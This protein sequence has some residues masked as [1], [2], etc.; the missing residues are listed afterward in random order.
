MQKKQTLGQPPYSLEFYAEDD[1]KPVMRNWLRSLSLTKKQALG[2]AMNEVLQQLGIGV[3]GTEF[4]KPLGNGLFL[5][6]DFG[7]PLA[8]LVRGYSR[9]KYS[10]EC[11][12]T[13]TK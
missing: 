7:R 3:C 2:A 13:L 5:S 1:G 10:S 4:G 9:K 12:F 8:Q 6:F 11:F